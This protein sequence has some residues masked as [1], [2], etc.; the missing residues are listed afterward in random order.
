[1]VLVGVAVST[2]S[3]PM[4]IAANKAVVI[5]TGGTS[6][7]TTLLHAYDP[8][9]DNDMYHDGARPPGLPD[10]WKNTG[11][12][13]LAA[14]A[15]GAGL[16][17]M[18][19][20]CYVSLRWG[21]HLYYA[22]EPRPA[23]W[24]DGSQNMNISKSLYLG[25]A[26]VSITDYQQVIVV[27]N[28]GT[29]FINELAA[30]ATTLLKGN[31]VSGS[32]DPY[33]PYPLVGSGEC[34]D[35]Q[36]TR[37]WL[38]LPDRPRNCWAVADANGAKTLS[39]PT[40]TFAS[41]NPQTSPYLYADAVA[42]ANDLPTL[43]GLMGV[44]A[45]GLVNTVAS[46]NSYVTSGTDPDFGKATPKVQIQT[47]PYYAAKWCVLRHTQRNGIRVNSRAQVI[48][49]IASQWG[50]DQGVGYMPLSIDQE[51]VIPHLYAA[52][53]VA[54]IYGQRR[55]HNTL[56]GYGIFGRIAGQ[57]AAAEPSMA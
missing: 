1:M 35:D 14:Q 37:A 32:V 43:A 19:Y 54:A 49:Q 17:D 5:A 6:D 27:K 9:Y 8:R 44:S 21:T 30:S 16:A 42:T 13:H 34:M 28:D 46:Y 10:A 38:N 50:A 15:V 40:A 23:N 36:F 2:P 56:Y 39:W 41:P 31:D 26:G 45:K 33:A 51:P 57:N 22:F 24:W 48:D 4:N 47:P 11:D 3:G 53:E 29:R 18:S 12:G 25:S 55:F 52:G 20:A 7:N